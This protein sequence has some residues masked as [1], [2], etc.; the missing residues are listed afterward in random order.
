MLKAQEFILFLATSDIHLKYKLKMTEEEVL[1]R[2]IAMVKY[3]KKYCEDVEF[4]A[5]DASRTRVDFL[6]KVV[7]EVIKAGATVVNIPD[8]VGY[9]SPEE[10][11]RLIKGIKENVANID[12]ADYKCTLP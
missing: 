2:A 8:T 4:S 7:E 10:F 5:E 1:Q 6:Y 3:S 12:K 9:A 11:G